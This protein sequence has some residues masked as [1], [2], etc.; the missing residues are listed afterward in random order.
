MRRI[1]SL[2]DAKGKTIGFRPMIQQGRGANRRTH[3]EVFRITPKVNAAMAMAM[4]QR[5]RDEKEI[6]LGI[7]SGQISS[8]SA[9][10]FV[11]GISL[12]VSGKAPFRACWKWSSAGYP[13]VTR[14]IGKK[15]GFESSYREL[16]K[17]IC[18]L[19]GREPPASIATPIPNPVQYAS[20]LSMGV[21]ELPDRRSAP[22]EWTAS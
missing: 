3:S 19:I 14:Y 1:V 22:R 17:R 8:K 21:G 15:M 11:P 13:T 16:V 5:W 4:A 20:L 10:R 12:V 6:E 18:E 2:K 9:S 7:N